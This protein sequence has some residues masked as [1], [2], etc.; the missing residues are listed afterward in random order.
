MLRGTALR[1]TT[2]LTQSDTRFL[3]LFCFSFSALWHTSLVLSLIVPVTRMWS[4]LSI[5]DVYQEVFACDGT[6]HANPLV[7]WYK[8]VVR[9]RV[10]ESV[11]KHS[12]CFTIPQLFVEHVS[13]TIHILLSCFPNCSTCGY[14][15][16]G[17]NAA[18]YIK[19]TKRNCG[20]QTCM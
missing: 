15:Q 19:V 1:K 6:A 14:R 12:V 13:G 11:C 3:L 8:S 9:A 2:R 5:K 17:R 18:H 16:H 4:V 20:M 7:S 10:V